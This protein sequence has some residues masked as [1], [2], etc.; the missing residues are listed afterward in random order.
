MSGAAD[1]Y[2]KFKKNNSKN[3]F[4]RCAVF[5]ESK[6]WGFS[7]PLNDGLCTDTT[8]FCEKYI[9]SIHTKVYEKKITDF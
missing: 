3:I 6:T 4:L 7:Y 1:K 5:R 2:E 9:N 8:Y